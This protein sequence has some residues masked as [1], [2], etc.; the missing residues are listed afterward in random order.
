[1]DAHIDKITKIPIALTFIYTCTTLTSKFTT[2][3]MVFS[4]TCTICEGPKLDAQ[5]FQSVMPV[6]C[7]YESNCQHEYLF[8]VKQYLY[9]DILEQHT[10]IYQMIVLYFS[11]QGE[12]ILSILIANVM[13]LHLSMQEEDIL[14][15]TDGKCH[16][17]TLQSTCRPLCNIGM[18]LI[19]ILNMLMSRDQKDYL[20]A[21]CHVR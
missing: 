3:L 13:R 2:L 20:N 11:M 21:K 18:H 5:R 4:V 8:R 12:D 17:C 14:E 7:Q 10:G 1:M 9:Y 16:L 19:T 6:N 15:D